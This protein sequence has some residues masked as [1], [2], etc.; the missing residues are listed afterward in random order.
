M[1]PHAI[2]TRKGNSAS[3][4]SYRGA[5]PQGYLFAVRAA[6]STAP[7][8]VPPEWSDVG[9]MMR[10][11]VAW[12][13]GDAALRV[14][15]RAAIASRTPRA[16]SKWC[17]DWC[18]RGILIANKAATRVMSYSLAPKYAELTANE[19]GEAE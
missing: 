15:V 2:I 16:V 13:R 3:N 1:K 10:E 14:P 11:L 9:P 12:Y 4:S 6:G 5:M 17:A 18:E 8:Y 7:V 19:I